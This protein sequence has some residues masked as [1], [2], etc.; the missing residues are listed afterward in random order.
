MHSG[1]WGRIEA[2]FCYGVEMRRRENDTTSVRFGA[3]KTGVLGEVATAGPEASHSGPGP[4][5][6]RILEYLALQEHGYY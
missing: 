4:F 5:T 2:D 1:F 3:S 6:R